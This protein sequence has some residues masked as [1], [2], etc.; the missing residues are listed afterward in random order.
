MLLFSIIFSGS[1]VAV[2]VRVTN[3]EPWRQK[4]TTLA[5]KLNILF[6]AMQCK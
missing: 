4:N 1:Q 6:S 5:S 2:L 3:Y